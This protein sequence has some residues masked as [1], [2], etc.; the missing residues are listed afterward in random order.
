ME[1]GDCPNSTEAST[2]CNL[3]LINDFNTLRL[4]KEIKKN[5]L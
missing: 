2:Q 4:F 5:I 1:H 3:K